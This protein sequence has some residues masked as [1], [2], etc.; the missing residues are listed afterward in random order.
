MAK[1]V[2]SLNLYLAHPLTSHPHLFSHCFEAVRL[3]IRQP[4]AQLQ[5]ARCARREIQQHFL[6]RLLQCQRKHH[7]VWRWAVLVGDVIA[8]MPPLIVTDGR[9]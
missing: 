3:A 5:N 2:Q 6:Q 1:P 7:L 9:L 8:Q 4:I